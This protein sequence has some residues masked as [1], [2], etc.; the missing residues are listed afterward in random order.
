MKWEIAMLQKK[1]EDRVNYESVWQ[2]SIEYFRKVND[3]FNVRLY[4]K[5]LAEHYTKN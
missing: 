2:E 3:L 5:E 1:F 4:L